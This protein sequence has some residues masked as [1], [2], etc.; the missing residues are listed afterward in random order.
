M[1]LVDD[2]PMQ[3][4]PRHAPADRA[5]PSRAEE[6]SLEL[7]R[8]VRREREHAERIRRLELALRA[9]LADLQS[10]MNAREPLSVPRDLPT[11][12]REAYAALDA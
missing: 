2:A 7:A 9:V 8:L 11:V 12:L 10:R 4:P 6:L 1:S 3:L 5:A